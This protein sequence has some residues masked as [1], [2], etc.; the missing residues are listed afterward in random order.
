MEKVYW[1]MPILLGIA[2][3]NR[4]AYPRAFKQNNATTNCNQVIKRGQANLVS[5][6]LLMKVSDKD[7]TK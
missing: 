5:T 4:P 7:T 3:K 2:G 6:V 1:Q